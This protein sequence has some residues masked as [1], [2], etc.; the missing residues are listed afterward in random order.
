MLCFTEK[1]VSSLHSLFYPL[2]M[3]L[4]PEWAHDFSLQSFSYM[5]KLL[6]I[7]YDL[8]EDKIKVGNLYW[9]F[10]IGLAAGLDKNATALDFFFKLS[11]G[12]IEVGT[13]TCQGQ[14]GNP[15]PRIERLIKERSLLNR[16]GFN[17]VGAKDIFENIKKSNCCHKVLGVNIGKNKQVNEEEA[18]FDYQKLYQVFSEV[19][20]YLVINIS[21]PNT[22]GLRAFQSRNSLDVLLTCL[23][24]ERKKRPKDLY[25]KISPDLKKEEVKD[26]IEIAINHKITGLIATNTTLRPDL[27]VGGI[28]GQL[29]KE[30]STMIRN[31]CLEMAKGRLEIIGVGG[32]E[33]IFDLWDFWSR[34][35]KVMQIYTSFIYQGPKLLLSLKHQ[36][37][38]IKLKNNLKDMTEVIEFAR[39][40]PDYLSSQS[41]LK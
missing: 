12:A 22:P 17:N 30:K 41:F 7:P 39:V 13:V 1:T 4:N 15:Y 14:E 2:A 23:E 32:V 25:V 20:D 33:G 8:E 3:K 19:A 40:N 9:S 5:A 27:G 29:L 21:S 34:G 31:Q 11:F 18:P 24:S 37:K 38:K 28:S 16:M 36:I 26:I 35:G 6:P 10:P